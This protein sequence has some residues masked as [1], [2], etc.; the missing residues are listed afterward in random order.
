MNTLQNARSDS[1]YSLQNIVE[2]QSFT[3]VRTTLFYIEA[4]VHLFNK[5]VHTFDFRKILQV[6]CVNL[7]GNYVGC[8]PLKEISFIMPPVS[9]FSFPVRILISSPFPLFVVVLLHG[10][11][12]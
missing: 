1:F 10:R 5:K 9:L 8:I 3:Y 4:N 7:L 11:T 12:N 6:I 2:N